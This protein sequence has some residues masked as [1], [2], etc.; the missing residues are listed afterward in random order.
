M[1]KLICNSCGMKLTDAEDVEVAL[2]GKEGWEAVI[3]ARGVDPKGVIP[4]EN[5]VRCGGEMKIV[6]N[7]RILWWRR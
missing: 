7:S 3:R 1:R 2:E 6:D 4:C 5:F